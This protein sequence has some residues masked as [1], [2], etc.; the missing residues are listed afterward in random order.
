MA[1]KNYTLPTISWNAKITRVYKIEDLNSIKVTQQDGSSR[2]VLKWEPMFGVKY[3]KPYYKE[4][5]KNINETYNKK[6][7]KRTGYQVITD[8]D[9]TYEILT[10]D[11]PDLMEEINDE[12]MRKL[13]VCDPIKL[14]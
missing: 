7:F 13:G 11:L 14:V 8:L 10:K 6:D 1:D 3:Q 12:K 5:I 9:N 4:Y 2:I